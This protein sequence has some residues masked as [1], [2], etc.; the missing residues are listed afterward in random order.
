[1]RYAAGGSQGVPEGHRL[2]TA[3][4]ARPSELSRSDAAAIA[5]LN[6]NA[7]V[8]TEE[9]ALD[10]I[11]LT[12][13]VQTV[14]PDFRFPSWQASPTKGG[15]GGGPS[16]RQQDWD[17]DIMSLSRLS[18][19]SAPSPAS[20]ALRARGGGLCGP[21][22][23]P[24]ALGVTSEQ[25]DEGLEGSGSTLVDAPG[26]L[27]TQQAPYDGSFEPGGPC[28]SGTGDDEYEDDFE[29]IDDDE[30][31]SDVQS[32]QVLDTGHQD[33]RML[34]E[35]VAALNSLVCQKIKVL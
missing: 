28:G 23:E 6:P 10:P 8:I 9:E 33:L 20:S 26:H 13:K 31:A 5:A 2:D 21:P 22:T 15:L 24:H 12:D 19:N 4:V 27:A 11:A 25:L 29:P 18:V 35:S 1:M 17:A 3:R 32:Q 14:M 16:S 7:A 30:V 34:R